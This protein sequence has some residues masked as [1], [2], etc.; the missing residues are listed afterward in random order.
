MS[1]WVLDTDHLSLLQRANPIVLQRIATINPQDIAVTVVTVEEQ[2]RG[3]LDV[4]RQASR[5]SEVNK[6]VSAY[7]GLKDTLDDFNSIRI[8]KFS[9]LA[10]TYYLELWRRKIRIG[11]QDLR[12]AAIVLS[13][14]GILV[15]RN[16]RDFSQVPGLILE[17]W[18]V[19]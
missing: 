5:S 18:T 2:L 11:T 17:D 15:T 9:Q 8:L 12:I 3:R 6:L 4:I 10:Y 14:N 16:R 19:F 7:A 13:V 1:L